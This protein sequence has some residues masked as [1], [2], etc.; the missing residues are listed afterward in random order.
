M[1]DVERSWQRIE[2]WLRDN[3]PDTYA[4]LNPP[5]SEAAIAAAEEFVGVAFP[6]DVVA[7]LRVHDGVAAGPAEFDLAGRYSPSSVARIKSN[8]Q[9]LTDLLLDQFK[10]DDMSG[11]WW[12]PQWVPIAE[13]NAACQL[14]VDGRAGEDTDR[15]AMRDKS[16]GLRS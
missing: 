1:D 14:I 15:V 9:M 10:D 2:N 11:Y 8:W 16:E 6:P 5:A 12:H 3:A 13:D 7:S 4:T